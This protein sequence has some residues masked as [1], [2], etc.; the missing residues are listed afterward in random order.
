MG[1]L[2]NGAL[3]LSTSK[4]NGKSGTDDITIK[5][6]TINIVYYLLGFIWISERIPA[7]FSY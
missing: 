7:I 5:E 6:L 2:A 4:H 3:C 1:L